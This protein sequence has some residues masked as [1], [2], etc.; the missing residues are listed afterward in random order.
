LGQFLKRAQ[1]LKNASV[2]GGN[3]PLTHETRLLNLLALEW[4][5]LPIIQSIYS[6]TQD[7]RT[8]RGKLFEFFLMVQMFLSPLPMGY[9]AGEGSQIH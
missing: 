3:F 5:F 4:K 1:A 8:V 7:Y 9:K 2:S 6:G